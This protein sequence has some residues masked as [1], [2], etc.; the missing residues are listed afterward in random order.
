MVSCGAD[1]SIYFQT[2]EQVSAAASPSQQEAPLSHS[3]CVSVL[4]TPGGLLFSRSHHVVEKATLYDM[5]LDPS[6]KHVAVACQ[7][8][9]IRSETKSVGAVAKVTV[10]LSLR[11]T[12]VIYLSTVA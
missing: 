5:D 4:Q 11:L 6:R 8:R 10:F 7:D 9:N 1:K 12:P 3:S 2:A